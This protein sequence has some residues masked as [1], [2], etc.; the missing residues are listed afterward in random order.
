M[1]RPLHSAPVVVATPLMAAA[2]ASS[3]TQ[4]PTQSVLA[5]LEEPRCYSTGEQAVRAL[6]TKSDT[7]WVALTTARAF[8]IAMESVD[9]EWHA[10]LSGKSLGIVRTNEDGYTL[11]ADRL[12]K[13]VT[14]YWQYH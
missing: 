8:D 1:R 4:S 13:R 9:L 5:V 11:L 12:R 6:L 10:S 2:I 7:G 3:T 14:F